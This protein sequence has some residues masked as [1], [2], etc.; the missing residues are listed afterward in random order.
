M[1]AGGNTD[2][3]RVKLNNVNRFESLHYP[4]PLQKEH[5]F[6]ELRAEI[7]VQTKQ[8]SFPRKEL[9]STLNDKPD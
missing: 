2:F 8:V 6:P 4:H 1:A 7:W 5:L 9:F 3:L